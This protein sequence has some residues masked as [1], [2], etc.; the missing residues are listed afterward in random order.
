MNKWMVISILSLAAVSLFSL[1]IGS[2]IAQGII[3]SYVHLAPYLIPTSY[4]L[5][6]F[7]G[8]ALHQIREKPKGDVSEVFE[9]DRKLAVKV[10]VAGGMQA[11]V[12]KKIGKVRAHRTI[13]SLENKGIVERVK[14]GNTYVLKPGKKLEKLI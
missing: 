6:F 10:A 8:Y 4:V 11:D 13:R 7:L 9:G 5:G 2:H 14:K 3:C 12:A 1:Y